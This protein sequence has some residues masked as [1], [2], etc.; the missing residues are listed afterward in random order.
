MKRRRVRLQDLLGRSVYDTNSER[1]GRIEELEAEQTGD[2]CHVTMFVLGGSGLLERLAVGGFK[3]LFGPS[4]GE[5]GDAKA[6]RV[7]WQQ[8]DLSNPKRPK[9]RCTKA[10]LEES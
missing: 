1:V 2:G 7:P 3:R 10:E 5:K 9:L 8:M 6:Q 4:R